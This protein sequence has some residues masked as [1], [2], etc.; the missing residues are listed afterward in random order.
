[1]G[2][3]S[4]VLNMTSGSIYNANMYGGTFNLDG[5]SVTGTANIYDVD[6]KTQIWAKGGSLN[7]VKL[8]GYAHGDQTGSVLHTNGQCDIGTVAIGSGSQGDN[9]FIAL[10]AEL[11]KNTKDN[12]IE[13]DDVSN[14]NY[15]ENY[16]LVKPEEGSDFD[17]SREVSKVDF[18]A[19]VIKRYNIVPGANEKATHIVFGFDGVFVDTQNGSDSNSGLSY[20][21][22]VKTFNKAGQVLREKV[23]K[24]P[25][26]IGA[27]YVVDMENVKSPATAIITGSDSIDLSGVEP[28]QKSPYICAFHS[29]CD[30]LIQVENGASFS[31]KGVDISGT[32][33]NGATT[34]RTLMSIKGSFTAEESQ[35]YNSR[36]TVL[37]IEGGSVTLK[38]S[39]AAPE[40]DVRGS[41]TTVKLNG[42]VLNVQDSSS[43]QYGE[44]GIQM[45]D[46]TVNIS[47]DSA[48]INAE[49]GIKMSNGIAAIR[50]RISGSSTVGVDISGGTATLYGTGSI[51]GCNGSGVFISGGQFD[52][53]GDVTGNSYRY[54]SS[55]KGGVYVSGGKYTMYSG[56]DIKDFYG[57]NGAA[58]GVSVV[59]GQFRAEGSNIISGNKSSGNGGGLFV[60]GGSAS[61]KG[62]NISSNNAGY[63]SSGNGGGVYVVGGSLTMDGCTVN[64]NTAGYSS[65]SHGGGIYIGGGSVDIKGGEVSSN[66]A[67]YGDGGGIYYGCSAGASVKN[68]TVSS[69]TA[70]RNGG[71]F[72]ISG[73]TGSHE[74]SLS[75]C[76]VSS[77]T[78]ANSGG[79]IY[80]NCEAGLDLGSFGGVYSNT[81]TDGNGGALYSVGGSVVLGSSKDYQ[82]NKSGSDGGAVYMAN[83]SLSGSSINFSG[84]HI[85]GTEGNGGVI[86][87]Q[88]GSL[89]LSGST[90][91]SNAAGVTVAKAKNGGAVSITEGTATLNN[92]VI[93]GATASADGGAVY[94]NSGTVYLN[95]ADLT[96]NKA[97]GDG[98]AVR[99]VD[100]TVSM[101]EATV[102][103][104]TADSEGG[105]VYLAKG[106]LDMSDVNKNFTGTLTANT[107]GADGG[108]VYINAAVTSTVN[109]G[110]AKLKGTAGNN[111]GGLYV[112]GGS[113][114]ADKIQLIGSTSTNGSGGAV[115]L[116]KGTVS[117]KEAKLDDAKASNGNGGAVFVANN[118]NNSIDLFKASLT[119]NEAKAGGAVYIE[120]GTVNMQEA[121]VNNCS[122]TAGSGG[123]V[124]F[125]KGSLDMSNVNKHFTGALTA[126]TAS[127]D[128][129]AVYIGADVESEVKLSG[130]KLKGT[131]GNDG[132]GLYIGGGS[133]S[134]DKITLS[135]SKATSGDG[136]A[137][138][139]GSG[140]VRAAGATLSGSSA[141][142]KGGA[143]YVIADVTTGEGDA[144]V[145]T[146]V[147]V[148]LNGANISGSSASVGGGLY[149]DGGS[150]SMLENTEGT[151]TTAADASNCSASV[152][153]ENNKNGAAIHLNSGKLE[154]N[155]NISVATSSTATRPVYI[156]SQASMSQHGGTVTG[157][158]WAEGDYIITLPAVKVTGEIR[159]ENAYH[160]LQISDKSTE[161]GDN[162]FKVYA[163]YNTFAESVI[164]KGFMKVPAT[165]DNS[166][167]DG[168][169][170]VTGIEESN[171]SEIGYDIVAGA[172]TDIFWDPFGNNG[173]S[174]VASDSN[175]GTAA[176][177]V[178]SWSVALNK[179]AQAGPNGRIVM[180]GWPEIKDFGEVID[181]DI[182]GSG[183]GTER[184]KVVR[185]YYYDKNGD[186]V[187]HTGNMFVSGMSECI[188]TFSNVIISGEYV[189]GSSHV[190][191]SLV[192]VPGINGATNVD[193]CNNNGNVPAVV[194]A[195]KHVTFTNC[196][197]YNNSNN[198]GNGGAL[199][200][201]D[202][203]L[204]SCDFTGNY[205][206][207]KGGALYVEHGSNGYKEITI[208]ASAGYD[209]SSFVSNSSN[210]DGGAL[211][212]IH[213][214]P[215][216]GLDLKISNANFSGNVSAKGGG[217]IYTH[218]GYRVEDSSFS[219]NRANGGNGGA[220]C[221]GGLYSIETERTDYSN[222]YASGDGGAIYYSNGGGSG[223]ITVKDL[224]FNGNSAGGDG[225][226]I[227][228]DS[229]YGG[230]PVLEKLDFVSNKASS[231]GAFYYAGNQYDTES[232]LTLNGF[233]FK[234]NQANGGNN[235]HG[236]AIIAVRGAIEI[237][238]GSFSG[239]TATGSGGALNCDTVTITSGSFSGNSA[240]KYGGAIN[241]SMFTAND[242][243]FENNMAE[244]GGAVSDAGHTSS[245]TSYI[246][247]TATDKGGA[248]HSNGTN[249]TINKSDKGNNCLFRNNRAANG[250]AIG[251]SNDLTGTLGI[252][253]AAFESN[254]A[255]A[256]GGAVYKSGSG[257]LTISS[258]SYKNN[259]ATGN[260]G[261]IYVNRGT[262][263]TTGANYIGNKAA[264]GGALYNVSKANTFTV[265]SGS[266]ENNTASGDGGAVFSN[267]G[268]AING[269]SYTGNSAK[270]GGAVYAFFKNGGVAAASG[271]VFSGNRAVKDSDDT[272]GFGGALYILSDDPS[273]IWSDVNVNGSFSGNSAAQGAAVYAGTAT[274]GDSYTKTSVVNLISNSAVFTGNSSNSGAVH[275]KGGTHHSFTNCSINNNTGSGL[276]IEDGFTKLSFTSS[277]ANGNSACGVLV[278]N[279]TNAALLSIMEGP[280]G[281]FVEDESVTNTSGSFTVSGSGFNNN[282]GDG[283]H[284]E[285]PLSALDFSGSA[286]R[287]NS[288][289][290][291]HIQGFDVSAQTAKIGSDSNGNK[292]DF[293]M[294]GEE[295]LYVDCGNMWIEGG[296][297]KLE[298]NGANICGNGKRGMY[299]AG[300]KND[301]TTTP[302]ASGRAKISNTLID[303]NGSLS[304]TDFG[305]GIYVG[306]GVKV[307][308]DSSVTVSGN[309]AQKGGAIYWAQQ[310]YQD[311]TEDGGGAQ[312]TGNKAEMGGAIYTD[313][314]VS[315]GGFVITDNEAN[316]GGA[317]YVD[318]S[319]GIEVTL[320]KPESENGQPLSITGNRAVKDSEGEGG[321][322][323]AV[324]IG[325]TGNANSIVNIVDTVIS[326]NSSEDTGTS[327]PLGNSSGI[328]NGAAKLYMNGVQNRISDNI[329][330]DNH[331]YRLYLTNGIRGQQYNIA[332]RISGNNKFDYGDVVVEPTDN[333][334]NAASD[335]PRVVSITAGSVFS[336]GQCSEHVSGHPNPDAIV[337]KKCIFVDGSK[338]YAE[339]ETY[340]GTTPADAFPTME[341]ALEEA[342]G[343]AYVIYVCGPVTVSNDTTW[344][345]DSKN[346][347]QGSAEIH[348]YTGF[349]VGGD[350]SLSAPAYLGDMIIVE[351]GAEL[352]IDYSVVNFS[353][354][355]NESDTAVPTGSILDVSGNVIMNHELSIDGNN[356]NSANNGGA[357]C[358]NDGGIVSMGGTVSISDSNAGKGGAVYVAEGGK[359]DVGG[360]LSVSGS[361]ANNGGG[362]YN[363]GTVVVNS[364][365]VLGSS[366]SVNGG[367]VYN[368]GEF[369][370]NASIT[371]DDEFYIS[372][373]KH[374]TID[375]ASVS[376]SDGSGGAM[377]MDIG[378]PRDGRIYVDYNES[379]NETELDQQQDKYELTSA[380]TSAFLR[381]SRDNGLILSQ[382]NIVYVGKIR[383]TDTSGLVKG[384]SADY[385][386]ESL[387]AAIT[388]LNAMKANG[389]QGGGL[390]YIVDA[391]DVSEN[392]TISS[393]SADGVSLSEGGISIRR[394]SK[395]TS[396]TDHNQRS[397]EIANS[398]EAF[399]FNVKNGATLTLDGIMIDGHSVEY[400]GADSKID[401]TNAPAVVSKSAAI[402]VS[403]GGALII[404]GNTALMNND[405]LNLTG[406][407]VYNGGTVTVEGSGDVS[408]MGSVYLAEGK[409]ISVSSA[410]SPAANIDIEVA[411]NTDL[412][413][414][415]EDICDGRIIASYT[416]APE[417][418]ELEKY[419]LPE[420]VAKDF[421]LVVDGKNIILRTNR[422]VYVSG[423]SGDD[424]AEGTPDAPIKTLKEAY[425]RLS[426]H[427]GTI[428]IVG[429]VTI[430]TDSSISLGGSQY[431][432]GD[433]ITLSEGKV[434][435][436]R[437]SKPTNPG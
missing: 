85:T 84:S 342:A 197:F 425:Y 377:I 359:L 158:V 23:A 161:K 173:I 393:S 309:R 156:Y 433:T 78:A 299:L 403:S 77:N 245:G 412:S 66:T 172:S 89:D 399:L 246:G 205:A 417:K 240:T 356:S 434:K 430:P 21:D 234:N 253:D 145:T 392:M 347:V 19:S 38:G 280:G 27:I 146:S 352:T 33:N 269:G 310:R 311:L 325:G 186:K 185:G 11:V 160:P 305:G 68:V 328:F 376:V 295:G 242:A 241:C 294:N 232:E 386:Y 107:A 391:I 286:A 25:D 230:I 194:I 254:A 363:E 5:G 361:S 122:A 49:T 198:S 96:S 281:P 88:T 263:S 350:I 422:A 222:N 411:R 332:L 109:M 380:L 149:M 259:E 372:A 31:V 410:V 86:F 41:A 216:S 115:Y 178:H 427:G 351:E 165:L 432:D 112:G 181:G 367:S 192:D 47:D 238:G 379:M 90:L 210:G 250:G 243:V 389:G 125:A 118:A 4:S 258:G 436:A 383:A 279:S 212:F 223:I 114:S 138:Y 36:G 171:V 139:I 179:L 71:G 221:Y 94:L 12:P 248:I 29:S 200:A 193:F 266:F 206:S 65:I 209:S 370:V 30:L 327:A 262:F 231:G 277:T 321:F 8:L 175:P 69:N 22:P 195:V 360:S 140:P 159:L 219:G 142:G 271:T 196:N 362:I 215:E 183:S 405:S 82:N 60:S 406:D 188:P 126:N 358:I 75:G 150:V 83:G 95:N 345:V 152:A 420:D 128:G 120:N 3:A 252:T 319:Q 314:S 54:N 404:K 169:F 214:Q 384:L 290:G 297:K 226:A 157:G 208:K 35:L 365:S 307:I 147:S 110:G 100:G 326:D 369:T 104:N 228:Y 366:A 233:V 201:Y 270:N 401:F 330:L 40:S 387:A 336:K 119:G 191:G 431:Y 144:A 180:S 220:I 87:M 275:L 341:R 298:I 130:A 394:Y 121:T 39:H 339:G 44:V 16:S 349:A 129:G 53:Y 428:Y 10:S 67:T 235:G 289:K 182:D 18:K 154:I 98:G 335:L 101:R 354:R 378:D 74:H 373:N 265:A 76:T 397:F 133:V 435:I 273:F 395:P 62:T 276:Y 288:G 6:S 398:N 190:S 151:T 364:L 402:N 334:D 116:A 239:N 338:V 7:A 382:S 247:N 388:G 274:T 176:K 302:K 353:G 57:F 137:M 303:G 255:T 106:S 51:S 324:Y 28:D 189:D 283:V 414:K 81:A 293:N 148:N 58:G 34:T 20:G 111:G 229:P 292:S 211:A 162:A 418:T 375:K 424:S 261:A 50:G 218:A 48:V 141:G 102:N 225:G 155:G 170:T 437:Y 113:V 174:G 61:L 136:G 80:S 135:G 42:G 390:I 127:A 419:S 268:T 103:G 15:T 260:G 296:D 79:G 301:S 344:K 99:V 355:H 340:S 13:I 408:V 249:V 318:A 308:L 105:A 124:H 337:M 256:T 426:G 213:T 59:D 132:G 371:A 227:Y 217:A 396:Y 203:T 164:V 134:A 97:G 333:H 331:N 312:L 63:S 291:M 267:G 416:S 72:Y 26:C 415:S 207:G 322:G 43:V 64:S 374:L 9:S 348:R 92:C 204:D 73:P 184:A 123:A 46:G 272:G 251:T 323:G 306:E 93:K 1:G 385:P 423:L 346:G 45:S 313:R 284:I 407:A 287:G 357:I 91:S 166:K 285:F 224:S 168:Q 131:A 17:A 413:Y 14:D 315:F 282:G 409:Y 153:G 329:Y 32:G 143:V 177:P 264:S 199:S 56:A 278:P 343:G 421:M 381:S 117:M 429:T 244:N 317:L 400:N 24:D 37:D 202:I 300:L 236:G 316:Y 237:K 320:E 257:S 163:D 108:A 55:A 52:Q 368:V 2:L 304:S 167:K 70:G 187:Y